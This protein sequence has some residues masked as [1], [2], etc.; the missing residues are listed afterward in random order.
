[1][2]VHNRWPLVSILTNC[3]VRV[4]AGKIY[5]HSMKALLAAL[6]SALAMN[7]LA[8]EWT[9]RAD[10]AGVARWGA[11]GFGIGSKGYI[12]LGTNGSV[13]YSDLWEWDQVS[14]SWQ[15]RASFPG[16]ARREALGFSIGN[17]GYFG[18]GRTGV[19][20]DGFSD[21]WAYDPATDSWEQRTSLPGVGRASP[22]AFVLDGKAYIIGGNP[23][24]FP[25]L[26]ELWEYDPANDS[27]TQRSDL[28]ATG[29]SGPMAFAVQGKGYVGS[30]NDNSTN[31]SCSDFWEWDPTADSWTQRAD[32]PGPERRTA[33]YFALDGSPIAGG[34]WNG[35]DYLVDFYTYYIPTNAWVAI[36]EFEGLGAHTPVSFSVD[37]LGYVGTGGIPGGQTAQYWEYSKGT[38]TQV[39]DHAEQGPITLIVNGRDITLV[40]WVPGP[41]DQFTVS[42][43]SGRV[44]TGGSMNDAS[45][46]LPNA[47]TGICI[48]QVTGSD[49]GRRSWSFHCA[50]QW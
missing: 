3:K 33:C 46:T 23:N 28:P 50:G 29:R 27:W 44:L 10:L 42:D 7:S 18:F 1:M 8:Q 38:S 22:S 37:D 5:I 21:L 43:V 11:S 12:G 39:G 48:L 24:S 31:Y 45:I 4:N 13:N 25:Y 20:Q 16:G 19:G 30:G 40:G 49:H 17:I 9:Q 26:T 35:A 41:D 14:D 32:L 6:L 47:V 34:G 15:Q 36:P 2:S